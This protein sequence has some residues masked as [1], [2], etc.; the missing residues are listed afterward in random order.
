MIIR[1]AELFPFVAGLGPAIHETKALP[2]FGCSWMP[3]PR[4]GTNEFWSVRSGLY[5]LD[6]R[7]DALADADAHRDEG[8]A[9]A[10]ALQLPRRG[11]GDAWPRGAERMA[12]RDGA[13]IRVDPAVVERDFEPTQAG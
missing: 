6:H 8:V 12:N 5:P 7:G 2:F 11:Q 10:A 1:G 9:A 13:A 3:G 4:P